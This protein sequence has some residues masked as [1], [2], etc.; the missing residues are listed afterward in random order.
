MAKYNYGYDSGI[1]L[2]RCHA[3]KGVWVDANEAQAL[4][5]YVKGHPKLNRLAD[6]MAAHVRENEEWKQDTR[7]AGATVLYAWLGLA[8][9]I[10]DDTPKSSVPFVT[11]SLIIANAL[12]LLYIYHFIFDVQPFFETYGVISASVSAGR[13]WHSLVSSMFLH[14]GL[15]HLCGNMLFLWIFGDNVE[16]RMGHFRFLL[17]YLAVGVV[18]SSA[19]VLLHPGSTRPLVGASGAI[20]GVIG[21]YVVYYPRA[22]LRLFVLLRPSRPITIAAGWYVCAWFAFQLF[23]TA[24]EMHGSV[25]VA[26]S[27]HVSGFVAGALFALLHRS[28]TGADAQPPSPRSRTTG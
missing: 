16:D 12:I 9:P 28:L 17:F 5:Q 18:A 3:C 22:R 11:Y 23:N 1:I 27:A 21:A 7:V 19:F 10:S 26:F 20:G 4:A 15:L 14:A 25:G 24:R 2:D 13:D 8:V 6:S